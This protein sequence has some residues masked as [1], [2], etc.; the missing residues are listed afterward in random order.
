M[1]KLTWTQRTF[2][3]TSMLPTL[4]PSTRAKAKHQQT[5]HNTRM[6]QTG[7]ETEIRGTI[8]SNQERL[9]QHNDINMFVI[10]ISLW[11]P[12]AETTG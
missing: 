9:H 8:K 2:R 11:A 4:S 3:D 1:P 5:L 10:F 7:Q 6:E 12:A